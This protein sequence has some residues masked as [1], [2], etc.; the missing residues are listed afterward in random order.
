MTNKTRDSIRA[1]IFKTRD[2]KKVEIEFFGAKIEIRQM[3]LADVIQAGDNPDRESAIIESLIK[4]AYVPNTDERVFEEG[5]AES[6]KKMPFGA[7]FIRVSN[8]LEELT[9]VN[10]L[11]K[12]ATSESVLTST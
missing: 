4:Y 3:L 7:D 10:F 8:A 11:D 9:E 6:F 2:V 1:E 5:D 12:K